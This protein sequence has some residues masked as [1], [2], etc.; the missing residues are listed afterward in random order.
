MAGELKAVYLVTCNMGPADGI[1]F[2]EAAFSS[3]EAARKWIGPRAQWRMV[4]HNSW[5]CTAGGAIF[6]IMRA[7]LDPKATAPGQ[8]LNPPDDPAPPDPSD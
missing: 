5:A 3:L 1:A 7:M 8:Q 2:L 4:K 6:T